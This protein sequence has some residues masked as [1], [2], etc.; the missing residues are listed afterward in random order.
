VQTVTRESDPLFH[1]LLEECGRGGRPPV[2]LNTSFNDADEP[3][4]CTPE[5]AL[6]SFLRMQLDVLVLG[7]FVVRRRA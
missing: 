7:P 6:G 1:A 5:D 3:I 2:L 4:V